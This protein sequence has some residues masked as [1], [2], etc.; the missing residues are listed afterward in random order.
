MLKDKD[1]SGFCGTEQYTRYSPLFPN[2]LLTDGA[3]FVA[4]NGGT[5]GGFWLMDAISS[6][7]PDLQRKYRWAK[8][9]QF[10]KLTVDLNKKS[11]VLTCTEDS[12]KEPVV[13]QVIEYTDFDL[14][15]IDLWVGPMDDKQIILLPS[16]Y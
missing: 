16:E 10:W 4:E 3:L 13:K 11:A 5:N 2:V 15:S 7:Q 14:P 8:E 6:Y 9:M 12:D 1:L